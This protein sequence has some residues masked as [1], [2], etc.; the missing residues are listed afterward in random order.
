M[1]KT[2]DRAA[3]RRRAAFILQAAEIAGEVTEFQGKGR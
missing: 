2:M 3:D 1:N